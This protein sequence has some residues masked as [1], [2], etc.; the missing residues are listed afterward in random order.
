MG[1]LYRTSII[2]KNRLKDSLILVLEKCMQLTSKGVMQPKEYPDD[3]TKFLK[4]YTIPDLSKLNDWMKSYG[5]ELEDPEYLRQLPGINEVQ[6]IKSQLENI[7]TTERRIDPIGYNRRNNAMVYSD[8]IE[9]LAESLYVKRDEEEMYNYISEKF[10]YV[11]KKSYSE[12]NLV[13]VKKP[14]DIGRNADKEVQADLLPAKK[15]FSDNF[16]QTAISLA[17]PRWDN[18]FKS[19]Y[20]LEQIN[21]TGIYKKGHQDQLL[22]EKNS[23][24]IFENYDETTAEGR[25]NKWI[26][27][28]VNIDSSSGALDLDK[29][30]RYAIEMQFERVQA[31][32]LADLLKK[33]TKQDLDGNGVDEDLLNLLTLQQNINKPKP[34]ERSGKKVLKRKKTFVDS[35]SIKSKITSKTKGKESV[36]ECSPNSQGS[37]I[38]N[39]GFS[40]K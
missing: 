6:Y 21:K 20:L 33:K 10:N 31:Q 36:S 30:K 22:N 12:G 37:G 26:N 11:F 7:D 5:K 25:I 39:V 17:E 4:H 28:F 15:D 35:K 9:R 29:I 32:N 2:H 27:K 34:E 3:I 14:T 38:K 13:D 8:G 19:Q 23:K 24:L 18:M 1:D 40:R 16:S